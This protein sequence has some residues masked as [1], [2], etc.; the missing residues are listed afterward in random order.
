MTIFQYNH[1]QA[2]NKQNKFTIIT[3]Q[4][5]LGCVFRAIEGFRTLHWSPCSF[6][7]VVTFGA[8]SADVTCSLIF[9]LHINRI[10][11]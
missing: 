10:E 1:V 7:T 9:I 6:L 4:L 11:R 5:E 2:Y 3:V 8:D